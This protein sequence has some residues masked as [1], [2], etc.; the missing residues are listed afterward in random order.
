MSVTLQNL[1]EF[2]GNEYMNE[3]QEGDNL[4]YSNKFLNVSLEI[5]SHATYDHITII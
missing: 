4:K 1:I 2:I 3:D 5:E